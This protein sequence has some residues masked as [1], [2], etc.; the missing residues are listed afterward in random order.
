MTQVTIMRLAVFQCTPLIRLDEPTPKIDDETT[1]VVESGKCN[2]D[3][4]KI[5]NADAKSA[6]APL[7]GRIFMI[8]PPTVLIIFH[9]PIAVP[10]PRDRQKSR[11]PSSARKKRDCNRRR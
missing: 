9:P 3:A 1:C 10:S 6:D 8:L 4:V 7:A 11:M 2:Q 5:V